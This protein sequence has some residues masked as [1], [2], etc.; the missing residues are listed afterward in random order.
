VLQEQAFRTLLEEHGSAVVPVAAGDESMRP[1]LG[2]GDLVLAVVPGVAPRPGDLIVFA[3]RDYLVVHRYLGEAAA[4]D[5]TPCLRTRGDGRNQLDP[6]VRLE[7]VRGHVVAVRRGGIWRSL[8]GGRARAFARLVAWHALGWSAAGAALGTVGLGALA[9]SI[10][11]GLMRV[12]ALLIPIV[13]RR[14]PAPAAAGAERP[15]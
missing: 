13:L 14:I 7:S 12:S 9:A 4:P 5:G 10:D 2:G 3:Q 1:L 11:G 8:E 6:P 15:V